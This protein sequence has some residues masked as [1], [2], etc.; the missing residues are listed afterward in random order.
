MSIIV[1][2]IKGFSILAGAV[3]WVGKR[4][5]RKKREKSIDA[6][7]DSKRYDDKYK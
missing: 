5:E 4:K 3:T 1:A 6:V 2:I 7:F